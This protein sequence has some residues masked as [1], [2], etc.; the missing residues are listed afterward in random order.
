M[1][2]ALEQGAIAEAMLRKGFRSVRSFTKQSDIGD[3]DIDI[4][5]KVV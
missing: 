2:F 1:D 3:M 5:R 4:G